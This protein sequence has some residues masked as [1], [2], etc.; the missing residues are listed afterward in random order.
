MALTAKDFTPGGWAGYCAFKAEYA[1]P[2]TLDFRCP[3][4]KAEPGQ[5]CPGRPLGHA[6]RQDRMIRAREEWEYDAINSGINAGSEEYPDDKHRSGYRCSV[7][8][9]LKYMRRNRARVRKT[10]E[11]ITTVAFGEWLLTHATKAMP[12][13]YL[14]LRD[15]IRPEMDVDEVRALLGDE[16]EERLAHGVLD[17]A[18]RDWAKL[19]GTRAMEPAS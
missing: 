17:R 3:R 6:P 16:D 14:G 5:L 15:Q 1:E 4:C 10:G 13:A 12:L 19:T 8:N 9:H 11:P 7:D 2:D 18:A